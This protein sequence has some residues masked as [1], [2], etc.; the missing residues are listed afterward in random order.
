MPESVAKVTVI[1]A[2][3]FVSDFSEP[4]RQTTPLTQLIYQM[5]NQIYTL[6]LM[7]KL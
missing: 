1:D 3:E 7:L 6:F 5:F 4:D 2:V